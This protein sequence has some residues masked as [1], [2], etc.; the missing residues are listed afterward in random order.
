MSTPTNHSERK[1]AH[2]EMLEKALARPGVREAMEVYCNWQDRD[3]AM[4]SYRSRTKNI[5]KSTTT[6]TTSIS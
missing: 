4:N 5:V 3:Q 6:N 1:Q 2:A